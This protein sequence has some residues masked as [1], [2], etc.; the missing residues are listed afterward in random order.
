MCD[1]LQ[2][3]GQADRQKAADMRQLKTAYENR[4]TQIQKSAKIEITRLVSYAQFGSVRNPT[5]CTRCH[6][7][8]RATFYHTRRTH[9][10]LLI[11]KEIQQVYLTGS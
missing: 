8:G 1:F 9:K 4:L 6:R 3:I 11:Y 7:S 10:I 5:T 2:I